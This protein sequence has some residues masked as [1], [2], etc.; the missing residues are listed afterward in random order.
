M[1]PLFSLLNRLLPFATPGT[2]LVQDLIHLAALCG[3]L[4]YGPQLQ[5]WYRK[6][7]A[8]PSHATNDDHA[9]P[10]DETVHADNEGANQNINADAEP[11]DAANQ[12]EAQPP[13]NAQ[14]NDNE[15]PGANPEAPDPAQP[16]PAN[17]PNLP[18]HRNVGA[19]KAKS[20]ARR[21]Q[22]RAYHEFQ[23]AQGEAQR[24]R[25]AEGSE[26]REAAQTAEKERRQ[27]AEAK[28][29]KQKAKER[30][31]RRERERKGREEEI[32][33]R[34]LVVRLVREQLDEK[35]M[36]DLFRVAAVVGEDVDEE[37]VEGIVEASGLVGRKGDV[38]TMV[39]GMGWAVRV[40]RADVERLY[41][42]A[43]ER[44]ECEEDGRVGYDALGGL[45]EGILK[46]Q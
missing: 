30:E 36:C 12:A 34:E 13:P 1:A 17:Q 29:E 41:R 19:K 45:L 6:S 9:Q 39:T 21:D 8:D 5:E 10:A 23:R 37:W 43:V 33:R 24:A 7:Q 4:Y 25:D 27:A 42:V 26:A 40:A 18:A 46:E 35:R 3:L 38:V 11:T 32:R 22:K 31:E 20:L 28:L 16:G 15:D 2:P 14:A 44:E